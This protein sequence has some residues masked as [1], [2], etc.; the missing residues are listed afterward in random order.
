MKIKIFGA[1]TWGTALAEVLIQ[2]GHN[3]TL[4]HYKSEF[5]NTLKKSL[6]HPNLSSHRL[7]KKIN[8]TDQIQ[9]DSDVEMIVIA[10]P[11]QSIKEL[12]EKIDFSDCKPVIVSVA[13]GLEKESGKTMSQVI[14][15]DSNICESQVCALYGP[16]HA[17]EV[18]KKIPT[19]I[20]AGS[21]DLD[22]AEKVQ[23]VF[24][25]QYF[26]VYRSDDILGVEVGGS[27][28][29]VISLAAGICK[30]VGYGDNTIAAL[31]TR[32]TK[33]LS[34]LGI[35][36][37]GKTETF[38]GLSGVGD[39]IVTA[40]SKHSRNRQ[41]GEWIGNGLSLEQITQKMS[42]VAEGVETAK[43]IK[44]LA[45]KKKIEM[46]ICSEVYKII[47]EDKN[48][49]LAMNELMTRELTSEYSNN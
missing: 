16:S 33:E 34:N 26:R 32:G 8:F 3:V 27:I 45:R 42:M 36:L 1:G 30:G 37:G 13:K 2:N 12:V 21:K 39:L 47:F 22:T 14:A 31:L 15:S 17:E 43:A 25:N 46:P 18:M 6:I 35:A 49:L 48:S 19:A 7:S 4:W 38:F 24:S 9:L 41:V 44:S 40:T 20:V 5:I 28:K 11:S 29:N 23:H 10:T